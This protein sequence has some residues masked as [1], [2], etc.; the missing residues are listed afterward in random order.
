MVQTHSQPT[1]RRVTQF[2][3]LL[4]LIPCA[5]LVV[6]VTENSARLYCNVEI[7]QYNESST[8]TKRAILAYWL[9]TVYIYLCALVNA[10]LLSSMEM[11]LGKIRQNLRHH[12]SV[13]V[14]TSHQQEDGTGESGGRQ[15]S[16]APSRTA[17]SINNKMMVLVNRLR[18][19]PLIFVVL[20]IPEIIALLTILITGTDQLILR[21]IANFSGIIPC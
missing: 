13:S 21:H 4:I 19:Y 5:L 2:N 8:T 12:S 17:P 16:V 14:V 11:S 10:I 9:I 15:V 3:I 1:T 18:I 20:W 6:S 7:P